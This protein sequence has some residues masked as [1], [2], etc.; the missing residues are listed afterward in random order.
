MNKNPW[1][2]NKYPRNMNKYHS[3]MNKYHRKM[4]KYRIN[5]VD[6]W[7][8]YILTQNENLTRL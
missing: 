3:K 8:N 6:K 1:K 2:M 7:K 5:I 4:N